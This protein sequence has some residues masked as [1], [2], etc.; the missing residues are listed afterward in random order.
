MERPLQVAFEGVSPSAAVEAAC[1]AEVEKLAGY[2]ETLIG[3]RV[4]VAL[5]HRHHRQGNLYAIR[6]DLKVPGG[7]VFVNRLPAAHQRD[8]DV[9]IALHEAFASARRQLQDHLRRRRHQVK[10]H[11]GPAHGRVLRLAPD[12]DHGFLRAHDGREVYFH[13]HSVL[14]VD[15]AELVPG[16]EVRFVEEQGEKGPSATSVTPVGRHGHQPPAEELPPH[17]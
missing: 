6:I 17:P 14:G 1:R 10:A 11:A 9:F 3:C 4:V 5:P 7:E 15:F 16:T 12:Q 2:G 13:R 8:E